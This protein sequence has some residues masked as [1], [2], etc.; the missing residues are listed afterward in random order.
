MRIFLVGF[1]GSGK[2]T[3]GKQLALKLNCRFLDI[4]HQIQEM[5]N[6]SV[7]EIFETFGEQ[8]FRDTEHKLIDTMKEFES[9]VISTGGGL[10]CFLNNMELMNQSG[11][12]IYLK[13]NPQI[14]V[15]R[16]KGSQKSRPLIKEKTDGQLLEYVKV[17]LIEREPF[18][19]KS[20][21]IINSIDIKVQDIINILAST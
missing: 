13:T 5:F 17:K 18:Y 14:L 6:L 12:T 11:V 3:I 1:M 4:D 16:L 7:P 15:N 20:K 9:A 19:L 8:R 10:P 2:T 21:I